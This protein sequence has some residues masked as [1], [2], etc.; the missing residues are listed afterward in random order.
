MITSSVKLSSLSTIWWRR[1]NPTEIPLAEI[2]LAPAEGGW[3]CS[4]LYYSWNR[5]VLAKLSPEQ[6]AAAQEEVARFQARPIHQ[7]KHSKASE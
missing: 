5:G 7:V 4:H 2:S 3:H 1:Y 6:M